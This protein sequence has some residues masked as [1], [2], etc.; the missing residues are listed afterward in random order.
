VRE[1]AELHHG[2]AALRNDPEGGA[3]ATLSL[4]LAEPA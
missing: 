3:I 2:R 1:I 4:P